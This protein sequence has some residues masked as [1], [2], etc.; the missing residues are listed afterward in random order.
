MKEEID[1]RVDSLKSELD[2]FR[3]KL[4]TQV[5]VLKNKIR[6]ICSFTDLLR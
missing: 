1:L 5:D 2:L 3:E 6:F 4:F